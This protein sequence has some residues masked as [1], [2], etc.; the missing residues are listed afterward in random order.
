[1]EKLALEI[2]LTKE[3]LDSFYEFIEDGCIDQEKYVKKHITPVIK[4]F[5][6][7]VIERYKRSKSIREQVEEA[8]AY[9]S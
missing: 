2:E 4:E 5:I 8:G 1:M 7:Q 9:F 6:L 3:E